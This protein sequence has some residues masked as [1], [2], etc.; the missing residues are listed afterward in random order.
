MRAGYGRGYYGEGQLAHPPAR[1]RG[2]RWTKWALAVGVVGAGAV[3]W[4]MWPRKSESQG[5]GAEPGEDGS[6]PLPPGQPVPIPLPPGQPVPPSAQRALPAPQLTSPCFFPG[7]EG[8]F[9]HGPEGRGFGP[10]GR[11]FSHGPEGRGFSHGPEGRGFGPEGR[12]FSHGPEGRGFSHGPEGRGF[13]H[14]PEGRGFSHGP[15]GRG[16]SHGPEGRGHLSQQAY[17]DGVVTSARQLQAAGAKVVLAP[18]LAH[19]APR[20]GP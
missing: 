3:I 11:G 4:F 12:G 19:L 20:I 15:E 9:S 14:G 8:H 10:E 7:V 16:F 6:I 1:S 17:E 18:H 13:S 2:S 5:S